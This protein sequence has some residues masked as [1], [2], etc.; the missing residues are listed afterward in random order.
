[1]WCIV[2]WDVTPCSLVDR[3]HHFGGPAASILVPNMNAEN[4]TETFLPIP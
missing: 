3:Y 2:V 1:L 4:C